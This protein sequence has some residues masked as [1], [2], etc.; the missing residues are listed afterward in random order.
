MLETTRLNKK[1][2]VKQGM[3][4]GFPSC[5]CLV[6]HTILP[7]IARQAHPPAAQRSGKKVEMTSCDAKKVQR[8]PKVEYS[9]GLA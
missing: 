2:I 5:T 3:Q 6:P 9:C 4:H 8:E 7:A 1:G